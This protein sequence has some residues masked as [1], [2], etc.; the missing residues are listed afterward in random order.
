MTETPAKL[1]QSDHLFIGANLTWFELTVEAVHEDL[2]E[3]WSSDIVSIRP[4][5]F[6]TYNL[7]EYIYQ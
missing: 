7:R 2:D 4:N 5:A 6:F 3:H 1:K